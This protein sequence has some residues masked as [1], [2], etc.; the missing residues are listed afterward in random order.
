M[1]R[2]P[3]LTCARAVRH[4]TLRCNHREFLFAEPWLTR[5]VEGVQE[6]RRRF[7]L[8]LFHYCVM[9]YHVR[10]LFQV[11]RADTLAKAMH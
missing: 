4:A 5:F 1:P 8:R 6:A 3:R 10:L 2:A 7:P 11:G 9:T